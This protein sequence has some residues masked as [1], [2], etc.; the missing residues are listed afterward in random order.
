M[1][2]IVWLTVGIG[3]GAAAAFWVTKWVRRQTDRMSPVSIGRQMRT[4]VRD[5]RRLFRESVAEGRRAMREKEQEVR[6]T[7]SRG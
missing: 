2:R 1:R 7:L 3:A 4:G 5:L 6:T